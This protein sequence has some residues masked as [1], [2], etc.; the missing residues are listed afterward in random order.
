MHQ[1]WTIH[2]WMSFFESLPHGLGADG[3]D[4]AQHD[5]FISQQVHGPVAPALGWVAASQ[6]EQF[7][8]Q[9]TL[10]FDLVGAGWLRP[11]VNGGLEPLGDE[12][13]PDTSDG[14]R[15]R[16]ESVDN[17]VVRSLPTGSGVG[18]QENARMGQFTGSCFACG[19]HVF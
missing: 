16:A 9:I 5:Q 17:G 6:L 7:L 15:A 14:A 12:A 2:G 18:Q 13:L 3:L 19:D 4:Q 11:G 1:V 10:D 8:L